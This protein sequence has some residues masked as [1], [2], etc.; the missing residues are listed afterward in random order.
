MIATADIGKEVARLLVCGWSGK[1]I[2]ELGSP[3]RPDDI[4]RAMSEVLGQPVKAQAI[5]R[6]H[7]A[8]S[9]EA[10]G[11]APGTT[12]LYEEMMDG[13]NSGWID[14]GVPGTSLS[15]PRS[16]LRRSSRRRERHGTLTDHG[17]RAGIAP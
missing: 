2:V 1:K 6:E 17:S 15:P 7:W 10:F 9:L 16:R 8:A 4:A 3:I 12:G 11:M 5:P 14:F 13:F